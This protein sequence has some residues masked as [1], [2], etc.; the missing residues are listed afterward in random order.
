MIMVY[1]EAHINKG[2][3]GCHPHKTSKKDLLREDKQQ[4]K[5]EQDHWDEEVDDTFPAS[6]PITKY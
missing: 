6:D 2:K 3:D 4:Q 5:D 1:E